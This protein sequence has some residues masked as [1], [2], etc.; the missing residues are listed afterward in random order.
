LLHGHRQFQWILP[1]EVTKG[2]PEAMTLKVGITECMGITM[3]RKGKL[4][5]S[6]TTWRLERVVSS[7]NKKNVEYGEQE[8]KGWVTERAGG[9]WWRRNASQ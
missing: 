4:L 5:W 3:Q 7:T 1:V 2:F 9:Q 8:R 6:E